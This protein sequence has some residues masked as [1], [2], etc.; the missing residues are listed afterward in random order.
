MVRGNEFFDRILADECLLVV[1]VRDMRTRILEVLS[2]AG[3][4]LQRGG[5]RMDALEY[6]VVR[7]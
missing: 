4:L 6:Q 5:N 1:P 7:G 2:F 3:L